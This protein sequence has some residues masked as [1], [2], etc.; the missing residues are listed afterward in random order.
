MPL[1]STKQIKIF[2]AEQGNGISLYAL[3]G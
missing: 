3:I 2:F 1:V